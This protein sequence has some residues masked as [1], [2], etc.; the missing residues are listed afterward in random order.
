[1]LISGLQKLTLLDYPG[2]IACTVFTG[3]CD[4]R[5]PYCHNA[6]LV[7]NPELFPHIPEEEFFEF[8]DKRKGILQGVCITGGEPTIHK[9][10]REFILKIREKGFKVKLDT[11]GNHPKVLKSLVDEGI[12]DYVA[13]DV[14]NSPDKYAQTIGVPCFRVETIEESIAYLLEKK[15][16]FEF[17]TTVVRELHTENDIEEI[18]QWI[19]GTDKYYL[20]GFVDSGDLLC[21]GY[22]GY[23]K[24]EME[25]L[26]K[27]A[28]KYIK[29][30][31]LRGM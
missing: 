22:S 7:R 9:D 15:V 19:E 24:D 29:T 23:D 12:I 27:I 5:C 14:K 13:M 26:L 1:M 31:E 28:K 8:L 10:L 21:E 25:N 3:G 11:N 30:A 18:A 20:Q 6:L 4:M 16:D 2:K 17:R